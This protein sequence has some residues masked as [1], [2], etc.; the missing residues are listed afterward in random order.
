M[1]MSSN[2]SMPASFGEM[3]FGGGTPRKAFFTALVVGTIL[4][5]INHGDLLLAG[6][7]PPAW[8]MVLTYCVPYCVTTWGAICGKR[9]IMGS[10]P[11]QPSSARS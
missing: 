6:A 2:Q 4:T 8:K 3:A 9:M 11:D 1:T 10:L 5:M 7:F